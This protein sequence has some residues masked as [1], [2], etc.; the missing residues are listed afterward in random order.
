[1]RS[2]AS[3]SDL[4]KYLA[5]G[6]GQIGCMENV[7]LKK[8]NKDKKIGNVCLFSINLCINSA[9]E[10]QIADIGSGL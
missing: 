8:R 6:H 7:Y 1:M 2:L 10:I 9:A 5:M 4:R 3:L